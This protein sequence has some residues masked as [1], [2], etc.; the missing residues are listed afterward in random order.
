MLCRLQPHRLR[1]FL[2]WLQCECVVGSFK[3]SFENVRVKRER[4]DVIPNWTYDGREAK[5]I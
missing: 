5:P 3:T 4:D 2:R 1:G